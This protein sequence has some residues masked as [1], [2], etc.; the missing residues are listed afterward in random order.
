MKLGVLLKKSPEH[1]DVYTV[2][3]ISMAFLKNGDD[4][5]IFL[6]DD[7]IYNAVKNFSKHRLFSGFDQII[8]SGAKVS[9]C[10][11]T[12]EAR[13]LN[14]NNFIEDVVLSSLYTL[15]DI[16]KGSDRFLAF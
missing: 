2:T 10:S 13:G 12:A 3:R 5:E 4:V 1:E 7:G 15:S 6:M 16:V 14:E 8:K 11:F 9:L